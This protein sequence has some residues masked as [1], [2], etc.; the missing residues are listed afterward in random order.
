MGFGVIKA[1]II[2]PHPNL[3]PTAKRLARMNVDSGEKGHVE[4][5]VGERQDAVRFAHSN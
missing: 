1:E 4:P 2:S 5:F 3:L